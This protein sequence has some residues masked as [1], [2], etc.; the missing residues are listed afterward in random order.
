MRKT[1]LGLVAALVLSS[2]AQAAE[3]RYS[4]Q[5][6]CWSLNGIAGAEQ[7]RMQATALGSYLLLRPDNTYVTADGTATEPSDAADWTVREATGGAFTFTPGG[8]ETVTVSAARARGCA[9]VPRSR[10]QRDRHAAAGG[11][12][13]RRRPRGSSRATCTGRRTSTSAA[14][15]TAASRGTAFG[16][17]EALP[18][19]AEHRGPAGHRRTAAELPQ[20]RQPRPAAR[21]PRL[22]ADDRVRPPAVHLG[23]HLLALGPAR[24]ARRH[25]RDGD[26]RQREPRAVR[27]ADQPHRELR[28]DGRPCAAASRRCARCRTTSTR[29]PAA[30]ARASSRSSPTRS[31]RGAW[32]TRAAWR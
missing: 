21:H 9:D 19:C 28:R 17:T 11:P 15:S 6:G 16:I 7:V 4:L 25:A 20:L 29:R 8:G 18:D 31:R 5:G 2:T 12:V 30:P 14:I 1:L 23:G 24:L 3:T 10:A 22:S 26:G 32:S 27:A 13:L